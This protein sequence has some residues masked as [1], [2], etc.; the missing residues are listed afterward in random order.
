MIQ[1]GSFDTSVPKDV[2]DAYVKQVEDITRVPL[3]EVADGSDKLTLQPYAPDA[4]QPM[5]VAEVQQALKTIGFF[6][7][8]KID[9]ICGYRTLSA[10]RLFQEYVRSV[11]KRPSL[12]DGRLGTDGQQHLKR[13]ME[14]HTT[15][16]WAPTIEQWQSGA[17][18]QSEYTEWLSLSNKVKERYSSAPNRMLQLVN[19]FNKA[20]DTRKVAAWDFSA[21][22]NIHLIGIRRDEATGKF[23]DV[24]VL[25]IKGLVTALAGDLPNNSV[26]YTLLVEEDLDLDPALRQG[27]ADARQTVGQLLK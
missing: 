1:L 9:G 27:L 12:P 13:W 4:Q 14:N 6:P 22:G 3:A 2:R 10:V 16:E 21:A 26:K 23:D 19:A 17:L 15:T 18:G 24:F 11:E 8:G 25:L 5:T 20:T 7:G